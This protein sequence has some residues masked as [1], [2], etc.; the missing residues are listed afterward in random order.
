[1]TTHSESL[2]ELAPA[3]AKAQAAM[4]AADMDGENPHFRS[5]YATL[6]SI[7]AAVKKPLAEHGLAVVQGVGAGEGTAKVTTMVVHASGQWIASELALPVGE[8][9]TPQA[10]GSAISYGRRYGL[11]GLLGVVSDTDDDGNAAE[12]AAKAS[13]VA[14]VRKTATPAPVQE[15]SEEDFEWKGTISKYEIKEGVSGRGPWKVHRVFLGDRS[16]STFDAKLGD[17]AEALR[18][19]EA[20]VVLRVKPGKKAGSY[21]LLGVEEDLPL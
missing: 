15:Q 10:I 17:A 13:P 3:L 14:M 1:M 18:K 6:A 2:N 4:K 8:R 20:P 5:R 11:A 7:T 12:E 19:L 9:A 21:E 16:A